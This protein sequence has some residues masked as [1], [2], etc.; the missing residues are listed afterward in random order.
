MALVAQARPKWAVERSAECA[1][2][3]Q[4]SWT[5]AGRSFLHPFDHQEIVVPAPAP[6]L[7]DAQLE[8]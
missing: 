2:D 7:V 1:V 5:A 8:L 6:V 4:I 3:R